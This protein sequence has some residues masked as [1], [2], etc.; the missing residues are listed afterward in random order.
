MK[1]DKAKKLQFSPLQSD[2]ARRSL[3]PEYGIDLKTV[4]VQIDGKT[5]KKSRAIFKVL[6]GLGGIWTLVLILKV[7]PDSLLNWVYDL[8]ANNR[9]KLFGKKETCRV[10]TPEERQRFIL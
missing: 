9:Y 8:I 6:Q 7:L 1:Q 10:P 3:P 5:Y 2:F 4:V